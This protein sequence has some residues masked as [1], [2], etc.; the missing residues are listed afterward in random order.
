MENEGMQQLIY[1][2]NK[3]QDAVSA[4]GVEL[5]VDLPQIAVV[6]EQSA[7]KSSVLENFIG[8]EFLPRGTGVV[9]RRPLVI[10]LFYSPDKEYAIFNHQ[11]NKTFTD[12]KEIQQE[13]IVETDRETGKTKNVS[14][15]PITLRIYSPNVLQDLTVVDLPG[16]TKV[17]VGDQPKDIA[18][19][20]QNMVKEFISQPNCLILVVTPATQD[21]ANSDVYKIQKDTKPAGERTIGV[22]TKL[23]LMDK[24]TDAREILENKIFPLKRGYIGIVSR[25][26]KDVETNKDIKKALQ[27]EYMFFKK[28]PSYKHLAH[29]M[30]TKYLQETLNKQLKAHIQE[31]FPSVWSTLQHQLINMKREYEKLE[32]IIGEADDA[33]KIKCMTSIV[34]EFA[35]EFKKRLVGQTETA[36]HRNVDEGALINDAFYNEVTEL[37]SMELVPCDKDLVFVIKNIHAYRTPLFTPGLAFDAVTTRLI[38]KYKVPIVT[39]VDIITNIMANLIDNCAVE[40]KH[41]PKLHDEVIFRLN[42]HLQKQQEVT[43]EKLQSHID[44]EMSFFNLRHPDFNRNGTRS[45]PNTKSAKSEQKVDNKVDITNRADKESLL[46]NDP[47]IQSQVDQLV[48]MIESYMKVVAK[49]IQDLVPKYIMLFLV[50]NTMTYATKELTGELV[51]DCAIKTLMSIRDEDVKR[52]EELSIAIDT[53]KTALEIIG[54]V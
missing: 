26:Q 1:T 36:N 23:D 17:P 54:K 6:G 46:L 16:L 12:F 25:S 47:N 48:A 19:Q 31:C 51:A 29:Q 33:G 14:A 3:L 35:N 11:P 21:I 49:T 52:R 37:L 38:E 18:V 8:K 39:A 13:I 7:G 22:L 15:K 20:I 40:L 24:G 32:N 2:M 28:H 44:S 9:T 4:A 34:Y 42:T 53:I 5:E 30:G 10:H 45:K 50:K 41:Y 43:K 27:D